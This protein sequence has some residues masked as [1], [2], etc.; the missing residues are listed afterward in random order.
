MQ[1]VNL[2]LIDTI[3]P[4]MFM[5]FFAAILI[6]FISNV[7][8]EWWTWTDGAFRFLVYAFIMFLLVL[9]GI[10]RPGIFSFLQKVFQIATNSK[11][12]AVQKESLIRTAIIE[13]VG[14]YTDFMEQANNEDKIEE[15]K[16]I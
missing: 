4:K 3:T 5:G 10:D 7:R 6:F 1:K 16:K 11:Y 15:I 14:L 2:K 8:I 9:L 13:L 12:S